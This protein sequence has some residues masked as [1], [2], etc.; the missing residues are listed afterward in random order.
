MPGDEKAGWLPLVA[1]SPC[2]V[3]GV[4]M[5][6]NVLVAPSATDALQFSGDVQVVVIEEL[7]RPALVSDP[8]MAKATFD[9]EGFDALMVIPSTA[10]PFWKFTVPL[11]ADPPLTVIGDPLPPEPHAEPV[12]LTTPV[13]LACK[14]CVPPPVTL[15]VRFPVAPSVV[16]LPAAGV[17][18]PMAPGDGRLL[19][20][21][22]S[23]TEVPAI[24]IVELARLAF[25]TA[26]KLG[27]A[28][29]LPSRTVP[30]APTAV[31]P[32]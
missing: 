16:K 9:P 22:P 12:P 30:V 25:G 24:V 23:A 4:V 2:P 27:S 13:L 26:P 18:P 1:T 6:L 19:V 32:S 10:D 29:V 28:P 20:D 21:P 17:V 14:H 15:V 7:A 3:S 31:P 5:K 11:K 8:L